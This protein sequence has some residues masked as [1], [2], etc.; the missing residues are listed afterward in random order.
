MYLVVDAA[1]KRL[2]LLHE[3]ESRLIEFLTYS[4][5]EQSIPTIVVQK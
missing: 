4:N 1:G 5:E 2:L 3:I